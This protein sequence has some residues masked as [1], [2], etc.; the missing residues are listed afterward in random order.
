[1]SSILKVNT[2]QD[3]GGN[4]ILSSD[5]S[6]NLSN[7]AFGKV[8]QVVSAQFTEPVT[9]SGV[10][11]SGFTD[12]TITASIT[13]SSTS[14]KIIVWFNVSVANTGSGGSRLR[15]RLQRGSTPIG[16]GTG[17]TGNR[18]VGTA[19][20]LYESNDP[21]ETQTI[22]MLWY[23]SPASTSEQTYKVAL[24]TNGTSQ[25]FYFNRSRDDT[26]NDDNVRTITQV[27]LVEIGA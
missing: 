26:D 7:L 20:A 16:V 6:G 21:Y 11:N 22:P 1:M 27:L 10:S 25:N 12:S 18:I 2:L 3:A 23:D 14:S 4:T 9:V 19:S 5:G 8:L 24:S 17:T 13:P 15:L